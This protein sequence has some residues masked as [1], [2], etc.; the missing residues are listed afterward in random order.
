MKQ[1]HLCSNLPQYDMLLLLL[2]NHTSHYL[3]GNIH[4][5]QIIGEIRLSKEKENHP[6]PQDT[7]ACPRNFKNLLTVTHL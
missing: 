3:L 4:L 5:S 2:L 6:K 7:A 1:L